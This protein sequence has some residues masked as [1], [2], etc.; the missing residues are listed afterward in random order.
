VCLYFLVGHEG[1]GFGEIWLGVDIEV[2]EL[3]SL[4]IQ[5]DLTWF[6]SWIACESQGECHT[7]PVL[8]VHL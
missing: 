2:V 3:M 5:V 4:N 8:I 1:R 6:A 7:T